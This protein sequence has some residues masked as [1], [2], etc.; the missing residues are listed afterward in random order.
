MSRTVALMDEE[1]EGI[2]AYS[3]GSEIKYSDLKTL[4]KYI[5]YVIMNLNAPLFTML[6]GIITTLSVNLLTNF[7]SIDLGIGCLRV[8]LSV[9]KLLSCLVFNISFI[10][11]TIIAMNINSNISIPLDIIPRDQK[12]RRKEQYLI[13]Y[14]EHR[15][16]LK[17]VF[18]LSALFGFIT[19]LVI[20]IAP[21]IEYFMCN[22]Q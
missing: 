13:Q 17:R 21:F 4:D 2:K 7:I 20:I 8:A 14:N 15:G 19:V 10:S 16:S 11:L 5:C 22:S 18:T 9:V 1:F 3:R 12:K 6:S